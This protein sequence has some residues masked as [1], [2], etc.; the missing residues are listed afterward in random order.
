MP[1]GQRAL[2]FGELALALFGLAVLS[3]GIGAGIELAGW[4]RGIAILAV[5]IIVSAFLLALLRGRT[6]VRSAV[7]AAAVPV[8]RPAPSRADSS[9]ADFDFRALVVTERELPGGTAARPAG[10]SGSTPAADGPAVDRSAPNGSAPNGSVP[11][12]SAPNGS[13]PNGS[14]A[15]GSAPKGSAP[16]GSAPNGSAGNGSCTD[17]AATDAAATDAAATDGVAGNGVA[18]DGAVT[19]NGNEAAFGAIALQRGP[20]P[21]E[22]L[23]AEARLRRA[24]VLRDQAFLEDGPLMEDPALRRERI[25]REEAELLAERARREDPSLAGGSSVLRDRS[26]AGRRPRTAYFLGVAG[27]AALA[28]AL[29]G[30][31]FLAVPGDSTALT[32]LIAGV[33]TWTTVVLLSL[34][35]H[36]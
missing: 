27:G 16:N 21:G 22:R 5:A 23:T 9:L 29:S 30:V 31:L 33:I 24:E 26:F 36:R 18:T 12:G 8:R 3:F 4:H 17:A 25:R 14:A 2:S 13:A 11:D 32:V 1:G 19:V 6:P 34:G 35:L 10:P 28:L 7:A 15:N 20:G